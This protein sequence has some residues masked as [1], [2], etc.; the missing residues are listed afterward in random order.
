MNR[1][2]SFPVAK[3]VFQTN[4]GNKSLRNWNKFWLSFADKTDRLSN[5]IPGKVDDVILHPIRDFMIWLDPIVEERKG[6]R[7]KYRIINN[8]YVHGVWEEDIK[9]NFIKM[10]TRFKVGENKNKEKSIIELFGINSHPIKGKLIDHGHIPFPNDKKHLELK[11]NFKKSKK[12]FFNLDKVN[13]VEKQKKTIR[14]AIDDQN[15]RRYLKW[16]K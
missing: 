9:G 4:I 14:E 8:N 6:E 1:V 5:R 15:I 12:W 2:I 16:E 7:I 3:Q 11:K 10:I 13:S